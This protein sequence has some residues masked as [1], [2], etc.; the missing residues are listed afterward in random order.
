MIFISIAFFVLALVAALFGFALAPDPVFAA[1]AQLLAAGFLATSLLLF[2]I[3]RA[4][5]AYVLRR[6]LPRTG[7]P[8][9]FERTARGRFSRPH[10]Q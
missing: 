3:D 1:F 5:G 8:R 10:T 9:A 2:I 4:W 6:Q 7:H